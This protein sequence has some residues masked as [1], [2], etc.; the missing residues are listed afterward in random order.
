MNDL[1]VRLPDN[2]EALT[3]ADFAPFIDLFILEASPC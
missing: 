1:S 2:D 3:R